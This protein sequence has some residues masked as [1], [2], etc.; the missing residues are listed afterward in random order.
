MAETEDTPGANFSS[1][2][3]RAFVKRIEKLEKD[4]EALLADIREVYAEAKSTGFDKKT[5]REVIKQR[6]IDEQKRTEQFELFD[7]YWSTVHEGKAA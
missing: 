5:L 2:Q 3:L 6:K 1:G 4:K 7:L